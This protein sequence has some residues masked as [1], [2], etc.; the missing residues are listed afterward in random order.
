MFYAQSHLVDVL[1]GIVIQM[2]YVFVC[3]YRYL[4][5][6]ILSCCF[7]V[8]EQSSL[9]NVRI[10]KGNLVLKMNYIII[11]LSGTLEHYY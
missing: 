11:C 2:Y 5:L 10:A 9:F 7:F 3:F 4:S 8:F 1:Q 6:C